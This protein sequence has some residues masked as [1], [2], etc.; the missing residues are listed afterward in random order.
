GCRMQDAGCRMQDAGCRMQDD[1]YI[2]RE[3]FAK[4]ALG[5]KE[6]TNSMFRN[7]KI[8]CER[9]SNRSG[10]ATMLPNW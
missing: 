10:V 2:M 7:W 6:R 8:M 9:R 4:A 5:F 1:G 3:H